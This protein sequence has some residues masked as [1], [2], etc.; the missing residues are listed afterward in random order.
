MTTNNVLPSI[1]RFL[2]GVG[3][4]LTVT[5]VLAQTGANTGLTGRVSDP[6]GASLQDTTVTVTR[7]DTGEQRVVKTNSDGDWEARFL[8]PGIYRLVFEGRGFKKL[9]RDGVSVTTAEMITVNVQMEIGSVDQTV[10]VSA[11][12]E[13]VSSASST[14]VRTL[15]RKELESLPTSS[16]NFT[17]LLMI[18]TGVSAN[19]SELLDNSNSSVSPSVNGARTTNNSFVFNGVDTTSLLCCNSRTLGGTIDSGGGSLSRNLAPAP[20]TLE[21]VKLQTS[22]YDAATGRNG[23]GNFQLVSKSGTNQLHGTLYY[24]HQNDKL[25]AN[26]FFLN[27]AGVKRPV[28]R[29]HEGGAT[30]GGPVVKNRTFFFGSYQATRAKTSFVDSANR[31]LRCP[32]P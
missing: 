6:S 2:G 4:V 18:E 15:D 9:M 32:R 24:F 27:R 19:I 5:S 1:V 31:I 26:E 25:M 10:E 17:Q 3:L 13:M 29:R 16:R 22:L 20:E 11:N 14:M 12:A 23:G 8:S 21:E 7:V 30:V 28:L